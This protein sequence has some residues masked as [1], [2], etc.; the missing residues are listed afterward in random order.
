MIAG[1]YILLAFLADKSVK[2]YSFHLVYK[3]CLS[4]SFFFDTYVLNLIF[5]N[6]KNLSFKEVKQD[7]FILKFILYQFPNALKDLFIKVLF[8]VINFICVIYFI[9]LVSYIVV[10]TQCK[11]L[12]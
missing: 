9:Y 7:Y 6:L 10:N 2:K 3:C 12:F 4:K 5:E 1:T 8:N 11:S